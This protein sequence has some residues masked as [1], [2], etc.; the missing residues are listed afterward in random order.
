ML[1]AGDPLQSLLGLFPRIETSHEGTFK[2]KMALEIT[3]L[4]AI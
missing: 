2:T 4:K 3:Q 1:I